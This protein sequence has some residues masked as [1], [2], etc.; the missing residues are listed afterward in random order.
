MVKILGKCVY[1]YIYTYACHT[2]THPHPH[3]LIHAYQGAHNILC[4]YVVSTYIRVFYRFIAVS[5]RLRTTRYK[6][7][8]PSII[9]RARHVCYQ[10]YVPFL[11]F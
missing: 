5:Y 2:H 10:R 4:L 8:R 1:I 11:R 3:T 9:Y 7:N 6:Q